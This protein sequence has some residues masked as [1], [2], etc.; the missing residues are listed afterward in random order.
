LKYC[1]LQDRKLKKSPKI[2]RKD[3]FIIRAEPYAEASNGVD[4]MPVPKYILRIIFLL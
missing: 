4:V 1:T 2:K 3:V